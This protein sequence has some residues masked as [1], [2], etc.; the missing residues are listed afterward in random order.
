MSRPTENI[1]GY[2]VGTQ[3]ISACV[4]DV[5]AWIE[6]AKPDQ[7][8]RWLA[9]LNPHSYAMA[10]DDPPFAQA[11]HAADWLTWAGARASISRPD[12]RPRMRGI[13]SKAL[14]GKVSRFKAT[15]ERAGTRV[16]GAFVV[17]A[18][19]LPYATAWVQ[20]NR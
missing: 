1:A 3:N 2:A 5:V 19:A 17:I 6:Q 16:Q 13:G 12:S 9:C 14:K 4:A 20:A 8:C 7:P 10:L 18:S 11:L 15:G